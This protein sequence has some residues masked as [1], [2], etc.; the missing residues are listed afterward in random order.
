M[1]TDKTLNVSCN[2]TKEVED[3]ERIGDKTEDASQETGAFIIGTNKNSLTITEKGPQRHSQHSLGHAQAVS[4]LAEMVLSDN[5][6]TE[7]ATCLS[8]YSQKTK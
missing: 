4:A 3:E 5:H 7:M 2:H 1:K 8:T 6:H